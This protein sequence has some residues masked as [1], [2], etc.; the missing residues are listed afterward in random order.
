LKNVITPAG[1]ASLRY[2]R[3]KFP[4]KFGSPPV[5]LRSTGPATGAFQ[6][7]VSRHRLF[8]IV[9][10]VLIVS[11]GVGIAAAEEPAS[12]LAEPFFQKERPGMPV[13]PF[14]FPYPRPSGGPIEPVGALSVDA[15]YSSAVVNPSSTDIDLAAI[16]GA[17]VS[18]WGT[19]RLTLPYH[20]VNQNLTGLGDLR[21][22]G[23]LRVVMESD[24]MPDVSLVGMLKFPTA[25]RTRFS[26]VGPGGTEVTGEQ[27]AGAGIEVEKSVESVVLQAGGGFTEVGSPPGQSLRNSYSYHLGIVYPQE[28][29]EGDNRARLDLSM[30]LD[31]A[32]AV[33]PATNAPLYLSFGL[34][35]AT[36]HFS[37]GPT[38]AFGLKPGTPNLQLDLGIALT[39]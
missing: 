38:A 31:G 29:R 26:A 27:D 35:H 30:A 9:F 18:D 6:L 23:A 21:L 12:Q 4:V 19:V 25:D 32:S 39:F 20:Y 37:F 36:R 10:L 14:I 33:T 15:R 7:P 17:N 16:L 24:L 5:S 3:P 1:K 22:I 2:S 34:L 28:I 11:N 13:V 8:P